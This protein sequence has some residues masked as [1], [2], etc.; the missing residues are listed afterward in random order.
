MWSNGAVKSKMD[1]FWY[2]SQKNMILCKNDEKVPTIQFIVFAG[3]VSSDWSSLLR[4][5][6][7]WLL[8]SEKTNSF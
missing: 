4:V 1:I 6:Q 8:E 3:E 5:G 7:Q 2:Q